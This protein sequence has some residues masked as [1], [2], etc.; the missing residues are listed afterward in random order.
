MSTEIPHEIT[1][2]IL[3]DLSDA[4]NMDDIVMEVCE[5]TGLGWEDVEAYVN[6]FST[7]NESRITLAQSPL[8]ALLAL[9]IFLLGVGLV[10][11]GLYDI[12]QI[13]LVSSQSFALVLYLLTSGSGIFWNLMLGT[14]MIIGSLKGMQNVWAA[15]FERLGIRL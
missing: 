2:K 9:S 5:K 7:E 13:Y 14:A 10:L 11:Y 6:H 12:Y 3:H 8:L 15:I 4:R 1:E